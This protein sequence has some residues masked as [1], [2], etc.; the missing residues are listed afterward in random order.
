MSLFNKLTEKPWMPLAAAGN[1]QVEFYEPGKIPQKTA[2]KFFMAIVGVI[3]FLFIV[4]FISRTQYPDFQALSGEA[5]QPFT[6]AS[7]LWWNTAALLVA[8]I[9]LK[10]ATVSANADNR[11]RAV[12]GFSIAI[13]ATILFLVGQVQVWKELAALGYVMT[14][15]PANSYFYLFTAVHGLHVIGGLV[16][17]GIV[18]VGF[19]RKQSTAILARGISLC[20]S[21]WNF[22][23][24]VWMLL[25]IL[26]TSSAETYKTIAVLCG[27]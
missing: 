17:L 7:Q 23:F 26:L 10:W 14:S 8:G 5:W 24:I 1:A 12:Y 9:A 13:F 4:T 6:D 21:Y 16:A 3:F 2:L 20:S 15:N 18:I 25:F 19:Y 22:L 11:S 27:F